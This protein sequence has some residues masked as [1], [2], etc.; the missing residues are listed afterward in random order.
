MAILI[1]FGPS[2]LWG[3]GAVCQLFIL[4]WGFLPGDSYVDFVAVSYDLRH[5]LL[6]DVS[7]LPKKEL[8]VQVELYGGHCGGH[9]ESKH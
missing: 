1:D 6:R 7:I 5:F 2:C 9:A 8:Q 3:P 4:R